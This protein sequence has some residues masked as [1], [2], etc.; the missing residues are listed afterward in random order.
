MEPIEVSVDQL[1]IRVRDCRHRPNGV[2]IGVVEVEWDGKLLERRE[3]SL[4]SHQDR[5]ALAEFVSRRV[6]KETV[7]ADLLEG[8]LQ[9][10]FNQAWERAQNLTSDVYTS[11]VGGR[12]V[13]REINAGDLQRE[14]KARQAR[15]EALLEFHPCLGREP[16]I[17]K[18]RT[19]LL[20]GYHKLGKTEL[21]KAVVTE[22]PDET[23]VWFTEEGENI[24]EV[25][26][27]AM[28]DGAFDHVILVY[29]PGMGQDSMLQRIV[30]GQETVV[31]ID[32]IRNLFGMEEERSNSEVARALMPFVAVC[33]E[34]KKTFIPV[35]IERK[36]GGEW[37]EGVSGAG[38]FIGVVDAVL[39]VVR[40]KSK[41]H[42][43]RVIKGLARNFDVPDLLYER[44]R[45]GS[46]AAIGKPA[47]VTIPEIK[48][49]IP[50]LL[51][52]DWMKTK[53]V[54]NAF[55]EPRPGEDYIRRALMELALGQVGDGDVTLPLVERD[56]SVDVTDVK[57]KTVKWRLAILTSDEPGLYVGGEVERRGS[58]G[59]TSDVTSDVTSDEE[60]VGRC[61]SCGEP[62]PLG[63]LSCRACRPS[64][65]PVTVLGLPSN[66][67]KPDAA[68]IER[69]WE[70]Y[71]PKC[72]HCGRW[73]ACIFPSEWAKAPRVCRECVE[74]YEEASA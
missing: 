72:R 65:E 29:A 44:L 58:S 2:I 55:P 30:G 71:R 34:Q 47:E 41:P 51:T 64:R 73:T 67:S 69:Y 74:L 26:L 19:T 48:A 12:L 68:E 37:G 42:S 21:L 39:W 57:G 25:R 6:T 59:A 27:A 43:R 8:H 17:P 54:V 46:M 61:L 52:R 50:S 5:R 31:V 66:G 18:R 13:E 23:I 32:S 7:N 70:L 1:T 16:Y 45:D 28:P 22:W 36:G 35:H 40:D 11:I 20:S 24:W 4:L 33:A 9:Q 53:D 62:V 14:A 63:V 3:A 56:P 15:G 49:K 60:L 38:A 10:V